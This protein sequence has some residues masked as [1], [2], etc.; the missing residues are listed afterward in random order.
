[1]GALVIPPAL[2]KGDE[3]RMVAPASV[4]RKDYLDKATEALSE[5]GYKVTIGKYIFSEYNQFAGNDQERLS[6]FQDALDDQA[7]KAIFCARGGYGSIRIIKKLDFS[8]F[9]RQPKWLVGFSDITVFHSLVNQKFN[10]VTIH[11]PMPINSES[12]YFKENLKQLNNLLKGERE[13]MSFPDNDLNRKGI[14]RGKLLGGNLTIIHNLQSTPYEFVTDNSILFIEEVGE[15][16]YHLDRMMNN[17]LLSGRL[18][19]L[20]GLVVGSMADMQDKKR[21]FGKSANEIVLDAVRV[22]DFPVAFNF[23][24]GHIENNTPFLLGAEV[25][26]EVNK[27]KVYLQII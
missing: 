4:V 17:L 23:P 8:L 12:S 5:L 13:D 26:L 3:I 2:Q 18:E 9:R 15:Q 6:D 11:A 14:C 10:T 16:L 1:M 22:F 24:A 21:P 19:K 27:D 20:S 25:K 7:V